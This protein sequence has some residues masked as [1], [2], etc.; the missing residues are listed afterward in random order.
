MSTDVGFL[1]SLNSPEATTTSA[2]FSIGTD[3]EVEQ[4]VSLDPSLLVKDV[5]FVLETD[6]DRWLGT[7]TVEGDYVTISTGLQGRPPKSIP[8]LDIDSLYLAEKHPD[9]VT[10]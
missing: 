6:D 4:F 7:L 1:N 8:I 10:C 3:G 9:V 2:H 5:L